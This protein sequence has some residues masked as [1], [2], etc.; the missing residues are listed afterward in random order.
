MLAGWDQDLP[1]RWRKA[2]GETR[3]N[4]DT[5]ALEGEL[6]PGE[7][8]LP[9]RKGH[10]IPAA[11][12]DAHLLR[13][14]ENT[15]PQTVRAVILGQ[16]PYPNQ[17]WAT[18]RAFEQGNLVEW[19][20]E[21]RQLADSLRR[22]VQAIVAART[23]DGSYAAGDRAWRKLAGETR[24]GCLPLEPPRQFFDR[25]EHE[26][27]LFLNASLTIS[28]FERL[29][30]PKQ[31]RRHFQLWQ[32]LIHRVLDSIGSRQSGCAIFLLLGRRAAELF[33]RSRAQE[34]ADRAGT[35]KKRANAVHHV[36]PAAITADGA[37]FL[38]PPNPF[39]TA[40]R[41]LRRMGGAPISW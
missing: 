30:A 11:P 21:P 10:P 14:F 6:L 7:V 22:L 3:L 1:A 24:S 19:P 25:L 15:S 26:G 37:A 34:A 33:D 16:D 20:D 29:G 36:H 12:R 32:P 27:V 28:V 9:G 8:I 39:C 31:C 17:A 13:A 40:N 38:L 5:P 35:W 18:G 2:L 4:W 23:G 41:L